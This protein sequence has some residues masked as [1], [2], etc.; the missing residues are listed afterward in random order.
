MFSLLP[1]YHCIA[2]CDTTSYPANIGKVRPFQKLIEKQAFSLLK[3]LGSHINSY[4]DVEHVNKNYQV[5]LYSG[6]PRE[7]Y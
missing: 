3:N 6:V 7:H 2:G 4:K 1:A 5:I